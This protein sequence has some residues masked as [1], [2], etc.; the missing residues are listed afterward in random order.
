MQTLNSSTIQYSSGPL[1]P[2]SPHEPVKVLDSYVP[3]Q[4]IVS[5]ARNRPIIRPWPRLTSFY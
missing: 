2:G 5:S 3:P 4:R 1:E